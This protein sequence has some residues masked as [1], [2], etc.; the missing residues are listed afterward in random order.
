V[1]HPDLSIV[2]VSTNEA[3]WLEKC[4]TTVYEHAGN[5]DLDVIV[6]DNNSVE[7]TRTTVGS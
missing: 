2:I 5:V 1:S 7:D 4:L 3:R 6:V